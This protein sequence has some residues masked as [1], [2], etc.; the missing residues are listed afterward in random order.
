MLAPRARR[1]TVAGPTRG[2]TTWLRDR[3]LPGVLLFLSAAQFMTALMLAT[4]MATHVDVAGG[5]ISDLGVIPDTAWLFNGSLVLIGVLNLTA[6]ILLVRARPGRA[7]LAVVVAASVGAIGAGLVPLDRG[8]AHGLFALLAFIAFN[9]EAIATS[10]HVA[11]PMA[12][13]GS[14]AGVIGLAFVGIMVVGDSGT[15]A[16]FGPIGHGGAERMIVYP[17]MLWLL[18]FGGYL[19][20]AAD[21]DGQRA[22]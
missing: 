5:A 21:S 2:A 6:G 18:A 13:I 16:V 1:A 15:T 7:T 17:V 19:I 8:A 4:S 10:R 14:V 12:A 9:L 22:S 11:G 20:G 3:R